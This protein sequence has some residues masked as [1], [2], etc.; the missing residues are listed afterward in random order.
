MS[1]EWEVTDYTV[2]VANSAVHFVIVSF[3]VD[4]PILLRCNL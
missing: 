4:L 3:L 1:V 2:H